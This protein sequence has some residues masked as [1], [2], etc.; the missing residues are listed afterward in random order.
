MVMNFYS[1]FH[2][3]GFTEA[4]V[5]EMVHE[6]QAAAVELSV[7]VYGGVVV[8]FWLLGWVV[9]RCVKDA[10]LRTPARI[11]LGLV[12]GLSLFIVSSAVSLYIPSWAEFPR[13]SIHDRPMYRFGIPFHWKCETAGGP[14]VSLAAIGGNLTFWILLPTLPMF[15]HRKK[16]RTDAGTSGSV[17]CY[18]ACRRPAGRRW[19]IC[20]LLALKANT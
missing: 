18:H 9:L 8:F 12:F 15:C 13:W 20:H 1:Y 14:V 7:L 3:C 5:W 17:D 16:R 19:R 6:I 11:F 2:P 4:Q 10:E